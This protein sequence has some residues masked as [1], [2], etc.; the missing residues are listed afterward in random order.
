MVFLDTPGL[1]SAEETKRFN[2]EQQFTRDGEK[3][4]AEA[5]VIGVV[6]DAS[7]RWTRD[8]LDV[9]VLRLL[10]I[11]SDKDSF[12]IVNKID[13][14]KSKRKLLDVVHRLTTSKAGGQRNSGAPGKR[15]LTENELLVVAQEERGWPSFR[16]VFLVSA[17]DG[18]GMDSIKAYLLER[19]RPGAWVFPADRVTDQ[20]PEQ[21]VET[22]V[23]ARL[24]D[25]LPQELPYVMRTTLT[26][27]QVNEHGHL[28]A[29]VVV[30]C[31]SPRL[32]KIVLGKKGERVR[33]IAREAELDLFSAFK[34]PVFLKLVVQSTD[35]KL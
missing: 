11:H 30:E 2:L 35:K 32:E 17:L 16:E 12:L 15:K 21:M 1:V 19:A 9:K 31:P 24:L 18:S 5:D 10:H 23:R 25:H 13:T 20:R 14:V 33:T 3:A 29:V 6:H 22:T 8:R 27:L 4:M 7:N 26:Y 34:Q 28:V